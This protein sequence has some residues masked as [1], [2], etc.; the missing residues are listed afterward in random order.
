MSDDLMHQVVPAA[1]AQPSSADLQNLDKLCRIAAWAM[2]ATYLLLIVLGMLV[3]GIRFLA[4]PAKASAA[5]FC[6]R[7]LGAFLQTFPEH[8]KAKAA[9]SLAKTQTV[10]ML[11][12]EV[13][14][15]LF[16]FNAEKDVLPIYL[17]L[18]VLAGLALHTVVAIRGARRLALM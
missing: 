10:L 15:V 4:L 8:P 2:P 16:V 1:P 6:A 9:L 17:G 7:K 5:I 11:A 12:F 3:P 13:F 18:T 14:P